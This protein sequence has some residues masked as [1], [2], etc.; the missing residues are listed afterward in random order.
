MDESQSCIVRMEKDA[1][2]E[3][4]AEIEQRAEYVYAHIAGELKG[5]ALSLSESIF[6]S[7][8]SSVTFRPP[9]R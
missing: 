3:Y 4:T 5:N 7:I 2:Y 1:Q 6:A 8:A 9:I